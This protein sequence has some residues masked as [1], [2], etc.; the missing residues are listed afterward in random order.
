MEENARTF[1]QL[2]KEQEN[3]KMS[4]DDGQGYRSEMIDEPQMDRAMRN[5]EMRQAP[6]VPSL[7]LYEDLKDERDRLLN[8]INDHLS[9]LFE[10]LAPLL[11]GDYP[12]KDGGDAASEDKSEFE[13]DFRN[14]IRQLA[15]TRYR[16]VNL[17]DRFA[18]N[19]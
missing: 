9:M 6:K 5:I 8:D 7:T 4:N 13:A 1:D 17:R 3:K 15:R 19:K 12:E 2:M 11:H 18:L 10:D 16:L 14:H